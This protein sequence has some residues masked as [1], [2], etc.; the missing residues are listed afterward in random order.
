MARGTS[1]PLLGLRSRDRRPPR[2]SLARAARIT[3]PER[4]H[5]V[6]GRRRDARP[7]DGASARSLTARPVA[8]S[9]RPRHS[10]AEISPIQWLADATLVLRA[11]DTTAIAARLGHQ[12]RVHGVVGQVR[13]CLRAI[14][15]LVEEPAAAALHDRLV[16]TRR[17]TVERLADHPSRGAALTALHHAARAVRQFGGGRR[18][19]ISGA[20]GFARSWMDLALMRHRMFVLAYALTG[21][22]SRVAAIGR[23]LFGTFVRTPSPLAEPVRLGTELDFADGVVGDRHA[24]SG[25]YTVTRLG[26]GSS[27]REARIV[28]NIDAVSGLTIT[29]HLLATGPQ[30]RTGRGNPLRCAG[31]RPR[32]LSLPA[33]RDRPSSAA[34]VVAKGV[35]SASHLRYRTATDRYRGAHVLIVRSRVSSRDGRC[36]SSCRVHVRGG[37]SRGHGQRRHLE[38]S[39]RLGLR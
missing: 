6:L 24:G 18:S 10:G 1:P 3:W 4:R 5:C 31:A 9:P 36:D 34:V 21:R 30:R 15:E 17:T 20:Q 27:G 11:Q 12:A 7:R 13:A 16:S 28:L 23:R 22:P 19:A 38:R 29:L 32:G 8:A 25:L 37:V 2:P 26:I 39:D 14:A 35:A 33:G